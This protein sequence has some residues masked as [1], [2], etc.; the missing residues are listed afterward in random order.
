M[1]NA[2]QLGL[3][4]A[5]DAAEVADVGALAADAG[6]EEAGA[7]A[8]G[9][10]EGAADEADSSGDSCL[11]GGQSFTAGTAVLLANGKT[12]AIS[13]LRPGQKVLATDTKTGKNHVETVT[14][15]LV[16]YDKD[17][18]DLRVKSGEKS[19]VIGT[20]SNH[21][22]WVPGNAGHLGRWV[23]AGALKHGTHLRA[24]GGDGAVVTGGWVPSQRDGWMWDLTITPSHD[25]YINTAAASVL[26]H[27]E[28]SPCE[29]IGAKG[30]QVTSQEVGRGEGWRIDVENPNPGERP[31][32]LHF[33]DYSG[34]KYQYDFESG[35]FDGMPGRLAKASMNNPLVQRAIARGLQYL[36][37]GG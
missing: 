21:L 13:K 27:N 8:E 32:Q 19:A 23:K 25:F 16:H 14:A 29:M 1:V 36:G 10:A 9:T 11:I 37:M 20:T 33:Q 3:D 26:V 22:F 30:V 35:A 24:P 15:V 6:A 5:T 18:Y 4:P 17:L 31:G 28:D 7:A 34:N 2:L 12:E